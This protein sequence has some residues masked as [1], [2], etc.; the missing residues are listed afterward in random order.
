MKNNNSEKDKNH[1]TINS[2]NPVHHTK[3]FVPGGYLSTFL[4]GKMFATG[5]MRNE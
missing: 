4:K 5:A 1:T 2:H 3:G